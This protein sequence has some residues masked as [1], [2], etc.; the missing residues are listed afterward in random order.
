LSK[1]STVTFVLTVD[2]AC[3]LD[4]VTLVTASDLP[5]TTYYIETPAVTTTYTSAF[6]H[7]NTACPLVFS[8]TE[9]S[10]AYSAAFI[11]NFDTATGIITISTDS[12]TF[13]KVSKTLA[14]TCTSQYSS[15][16]NA[17]QTDSFVLTLK[18]ECWD[19]V[20]TAPVLTAT[21]TWDLWAQ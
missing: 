4:E 18:D 13:D 19:S 12:L 7:T 10:A 11:T 17:A 2:N 9:D 8:L 21:Y 6:T 20:L 15:H 5:D 1:D 3:S 16:G 14:I